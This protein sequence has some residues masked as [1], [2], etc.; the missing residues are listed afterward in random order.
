MKW[1][2]RRQQC[3]GLDCLSYF[4]FLA[5]GV[6]SLDFIISWAHT[7][8]KA[9]AHKCCCNCAV[10]RF[11]FITFAVYCLSSALSI[12]PDCS[13]A[14]LMTGRVRLCCPRDCLTIFNKLQNNQ[15]HFFPVLHQLSESMDA[16]CCF[17]RR[18][19]LDPFFLL[20]AHGSYTGYC[21]PL[22]LCPTRWN[23]DAANEWQQEQT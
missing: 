20:A 5:L 3:G 15:L 6:F 13:N 12:S 7:R 22:D 11:S 18:R 8:C 17:Y 1:E 16:F 4:S 21:D 14:P 19:I 9:A 2:V 10:T 23:F